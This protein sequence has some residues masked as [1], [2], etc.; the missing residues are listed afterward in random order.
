MEHEEKRCLVLVKMYEQTKSAGLTCRRCGVSRPTLLKWWKRYQTQGKAGL[1]SNSRRPHFSPL[2]KVDER[3][4][5][6][7]LAMRKNRK[8]G[9]KRIQSELNRCILFLCL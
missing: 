1:Q 9:T 3:I 4:K 7:V 2:A 5:A 6:L 8:L